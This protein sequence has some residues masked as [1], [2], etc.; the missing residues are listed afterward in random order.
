[1][2]P[3]L[4]FGL[5]PLTLES[6]VV[7]TEPVIFDLDVQQAREIQSLYAKTPGVFF[8]HAGHTHRNHRTQPTVARRV[9]FQEVA[10]TNAGQFRR[11]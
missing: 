5:H 2:Q 3:P 1:M 10:A 8:H 11:S 7:N 4:V 6:T 9:T